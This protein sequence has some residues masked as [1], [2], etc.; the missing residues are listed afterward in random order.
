MRDIKMGN[1]VRL[2]R[3][4]AGLT[5]QELAEQINV[6]RQTIGLIES[7]KYNPTIKLCLM[8]AHVTGTQLGDLFWIVEMEDK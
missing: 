6:T 5:Q 4:E 2:A 7:D 1:R 3:M 8:L